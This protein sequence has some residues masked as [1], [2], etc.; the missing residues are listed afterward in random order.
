MIECDCK[1]W[2]SVDLQKQML[3][4]GHNPACPKFEPCVGALDLI[5][6]LAKGIKRWGDE[7]DGIPDW[8]WEPYRY[9]IYI[10]EGRI[11]KEVSIE[12]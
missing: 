4:N 5:H 10:T 8:L 2:A 3:G 1:T 7:E 12:D 6:T 9:A 11:V